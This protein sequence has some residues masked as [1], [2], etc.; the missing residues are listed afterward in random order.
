[1]AYGLICAL[2]T[3]CARGAPIGGPGRQYG[4]AR[5]IRQPDGAAL[6]GLAVDPRRPDY[7]AVE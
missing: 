4:F 1:M 2:Q 7:L 6:D 5:R 3:R